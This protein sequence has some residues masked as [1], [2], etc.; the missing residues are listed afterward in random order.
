ISISCTPRNV[1]A[2]TNQDCTNS[3]Y[4]GSTITCTANL[5]DRFNNVLGVGTLTTFKSEAGAAGPPAST[6]TYD[7]AQPPSGQT[8]L[9]RSTDFVSVGGYP[10]PVDV[11]ALP[12]TTP[13]G[14]KNSTA[15]EYQLSYV[16]AC[17]TRTHNPRDGL[18]T[19]IASAVGEEGFV[20]GSNGCPAD[21]VYQ[22]PTPGG[23][24]GGKGEFFIDMGEPFVDANDNGVRDANETY[25]DANNNGVYDPPNATWDSN[26]VIWAQTRVLY[27][28]SAAASAVGSSTQ[29]FSR[30]FTSIVTDG[31][32]PAPT[33]TASFSLNHSPAQ[34]QPYGIYFVD[35]NFNPPAP[36]S[37]Y[38]VAKVTGTMSIS[39]TQ[40]P[41]IPDTFGMNFSVQYC[42]QPN[43]SSFDPGNGKA[44]IAS[45][46]ATTMTLTG[47]ANMTAADVGNYLTVSGS[48]NP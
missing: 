3:Q 36:S 16:D 45:V 11:L 2:L 19:I 27:T 31:Q 9:G 37:T 4:F 30:F 24:G 28:G 14:P 26:T 46:A 41:S 18:N 33:P 5:A 10:L 35:G 20:D 42:A 22:G 47:V 1:P 23:C 34:S 29:Q 32:S 6:P 13:P 17:G 40:A 44:T 7:P 25:V 39:M 38:G 12:A 8:G 48:A 21:G 15:A 43:R